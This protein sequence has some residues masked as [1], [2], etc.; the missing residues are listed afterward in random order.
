MASVVSCCWLANRK[1][2][3]TGRPVKTS[4]ATKP[5]RKAASGS[6][7]AVAQYFHV[8]RKSFDFGLSCDCED[9]QDKDDWSGD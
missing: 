9:A 6:E 1:D 3:R 2:T 8:R 4:A 7:Q 5:F